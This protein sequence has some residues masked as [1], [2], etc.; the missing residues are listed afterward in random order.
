MLQIIKPGEF[1]VKN[2]LLTAWE[3]ILFLALI[4]L[5]AEGETNGQ[6]FF[7]IIRHLNVIVMA[8]K[9]IWDRSNDG[10][11]GLWKQGS[12]IHGIFIFIN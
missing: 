3:S 9:L 7:Q 5:E 12:E 4:R 10:L 8:S 2:L 11:F 6:F 1:F